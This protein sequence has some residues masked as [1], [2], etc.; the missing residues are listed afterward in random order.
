MQL[1][2]RSLKR[3][4]KLFALSLLIACCAT[5][6]AQ[7]ILS[8]LGKPGLTKYPVYQPSAIVDSVGNIFVAY[9]DSNTARLNVIKYSNNAWAQ[10]G[11]ANFSA[12]QAAY[13]SITLD[14]AGVPYVAFSDYSLTLIQ[15]GTTVMKFN[16]TAWVTVGAP[17]FTGANTLF[18]KIKIADTAYVAFAVFTGGAPPQEHV[19]VYKLVNDKWVPGGTNLPNGIMAYFD[20]AHP[21]PN[22]DLALGTKGTAYVAYVGSTGNVINMAQLTGNTWSNGPPSVAAAPPFIG[23]VCLTSNATGTTLFLTNGLYTYLSIPPSNWTPYYPGAVANPSSAIGAGGVY[24]SGLEVLT[25]D[26]AWYGKLCIKQAVPNTGWVPIG[27]P[28]LT[29]YATQQSLAVDKTGIPYL[30]YRDT[31]NGNRLSVLK[32][33]ASTSAIIAN[34]TITPVRASCTLVDSITGSTPTGGTGTYTY[35]WQ[36]STDSLLGY[37]TIAGQ[38]GKSLKVS[39]G[40]VITQATWFRRVVL[41]GGQS[42]TSKLVLYSLPV[43]VNIISTK[44]SGFCSNVKDTFTAGVAYGGAN[45]IYKWKKNNILVGTNKNTYVDSTLKTGD[46]VFCVVKL[47]APVGCSLADSVISNKIKPTNIT[48]AVTPT[49]A[50]SVAPN[51]TI[52]ALTPTSFLAT[53]TNGGISPV[54]QWTKNGHAV[55]TNTNLYRDTNIANKDTIK[56]L[57]TS[58]NACAVP[59]AIS[60][61]IVMTVNPK[62]TPAITVASTATTIC[63]KTKVT[64]T[65]TVT[66]AGA[67]ALLQWKKNNANIQGATASSYVDSLLNNRDS[68]WCVLTVTAP[69]TLSTAVPSKKIYLAVT[70]IAVPGVSI[71]V[72]PNDTVCAQL[73]TSFLAK[74][75]NGGATPAYYWTKNSHPVG[76]NSAIYNDTNL[77]NKD[78]IRCVLTSS[79]TCVYPTTAADKI[80]MTVNP[81]LN[82]A[83][84]ITAS[85]NNLCRGA[86][87]KFTAATTGSGPLHTFQWKKNGVNIPG[88]VDSSYTSSTIASGDTIACV[89]DVNRMCSPIAD[90]V[91][92]SNSIK[93]VVNTGAPQ[94]S[95]ITGPASVTAKQKNVQYQV[96]YINHVTYN[97]VVPASVTV[98]SSITRTITVNWGSVPDT[99]RVTV[100]DSCGNISAPSKLG[101]SITPGF[102]ATAD[103]DASGVSGKQGS[104]LRAYPNPSASLVNIGFTSAAGGRYEARLIDASGRVLQTKGGVA[105]AGINTVALNLAAYAPGLYYVSIIDKAQGV[106]MIKVMKQNNAAAY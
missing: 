77:V 47:A 72:S 35:I 85:A 62:L 48:Q 96:A 24:E 98:V 100:T 103:K 95:A 90:I 32:Y 49:L 89:L 51:D 17:Q 14:K 83:I 104:Y 40:L 87:V 37:T 59:K 9:I 41:S 15:G 10:V 79:T 75:T 73:P 38:T 97:W 50:I 46:S 84:H 39:P 66:G 44:L 21:I 23:P 31:L 74:P 81:K 60:S 2:L 6:H 58:N 88:A 13:P 22:I 101:V 82:P 106:R 45:L 43:T 20:G 102:A 28:G 36:K 94:P 65:A 92:T 61:Y 33:D 64:F 25:A 93:M 19:N 12:A 29:G 42:S 71:T 69:C 54:Y 27:Q 78:T 63:K 34:N 3:Q 18:N 76:T 99:I 5:L 55:G 56:C 11:S 86:T 57:A 67:G 4:K 8:Y 70:D 16:G 7:G 68:V 52:C 30:V 105:T 80:I 26:V 1:F 53:F 91:I